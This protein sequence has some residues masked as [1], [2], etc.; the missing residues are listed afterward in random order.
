MNG[1]DRRSLLQHALWLTGAAI[2][3]GFTAQ[4]LAQAAQQMPRLL[5]PSHFALLTAVADTIVPRTD[6]PGALDAGV[7][8]TLD[9][10]LRNWASPK[11]R[12]DLIGALE[13]ID[14]RA[15]DGQKQPFARLAPSAR[16]TLL[17]A[18]DAEAL[19]TPS[20]APARTPPPTASD[21]NYGRTKQ[22]PP[23]TKAGGN[24]RQ[25][26]ESVA[27]MSGPPVTDPNYSKLKE[28]IVTLYYISEPA[29]THELPYEHAPGQW[30]PSIPV[31]AET[32]PWGGL[33]PI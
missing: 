32:R 5:D 23:Q 2:T 12:A 14:R 27:V 9:A 28:L 17:T 1:F 6:T 16:L 11:H 10:M 4:A 31:T 15:M 24:T 33:A 29:L 25:A 18:C 21:P 7:P 30:Q 26:G 8:T 13:A 3:P 20:G 19:K 22:E